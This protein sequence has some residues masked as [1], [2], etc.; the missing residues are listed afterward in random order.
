MKLYGGIHLDEG[1]MYKSVRAMCLQHD[2]MGIVNKNI[3][4]FN[5]VGYQ[6]EK[7]II[8]SFAE[9]LG[10]HALSSATIDDV[11]RIKITENPLDT[12]LAC[13]GFYQVQAPNGVKQ[14]RDGRFKLDKDGNLLTL[15]NYKVLSNEGNP[16]KFQKIP[17]EM[18]K[19]TI[20]ETGHIK[21]LDTKEMKIYDIGTIG[22]VD[23]EGNPLKAPNIK[24]GYIE[25]SNVVL[26]E[27]AYSLITMRRDFQANRQLFIIQNDNLTKTLQE[28]GR[29]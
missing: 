22:A 9:Y 4:G 13:K 2:A 23:P 10:P 12:A 11:G 20:D 3:I 27:E 6:K 24:Q 18:D 1:G 29:A 17:E 8:T 5:K 14:T 28:L 25:E 21:V 7:P 16:I 19:V 26:H 15:E